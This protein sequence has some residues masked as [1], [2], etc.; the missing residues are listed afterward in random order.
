MPV[1]ASPGDVLVFLD[2]HCEVNRVWLEPLL[3]AIA[4]DRKMVVCPMVD[5]IDHL[6]LNYYPSPI[7]RGAFNWHLQFEWD[8]VFTYE[9]D[10]PEG[11]T[12][13]IR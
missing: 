1:L 3:A 2:S 9:M 5:S 8:T 13:P 6:T 7:V 12:T 4:K 11:P 10:G